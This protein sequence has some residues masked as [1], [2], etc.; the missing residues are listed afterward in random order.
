MTSKRKS[1]DPCTSPEPRRSKRSIFSALEISSTAAKSASNGKKPESESHVVAVAAEANVDPEQS[2]GRAKAS[3]R[4]N[5]ERM[6]IG[7][8]LPD[9]SL[10]THESIPIS[11]LAEARD[12]GIV[13]FSYPAASTP[14]CTSQACSYRDRYSDISKNGYKVYGISTD[15]VK[16]QEKFRTKQGFQCKYRV[17]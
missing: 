10:Q 17:S 11:L 13:L 16:A 15:S 2:P 1:T 12:H 9:M 8:T 3:A 5:T 4:S 6:E 14:G 7:D